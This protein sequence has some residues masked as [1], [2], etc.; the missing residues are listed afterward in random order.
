MCFPRGNWGCPMQAII[1][2]S[3][4]QYFVKAGDVIKVDFNI[5]FEPGANVTFDQVLMLTDGEGSVKVGQPVL[6]A[7]VTGSVMD[8]IREKKIHVGTYRRRKNFRRHK[9]HRQTMTVIK[10][11]SIDQAG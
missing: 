1:A 11:E 3:G 10:I 5:D 6:G 7:T 4:R 8:M 2:T 9:G